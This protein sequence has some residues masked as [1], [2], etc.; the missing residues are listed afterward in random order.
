MEKL[1]A[2]FTRILRTRI[3]ILDTQKLHILTDVCLLKMAK[4][5]GSAQEIM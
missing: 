2:N 4:N 1:S 5:A 3:H